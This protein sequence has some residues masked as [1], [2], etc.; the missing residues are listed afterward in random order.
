MERVAL[1][2]HGVKT[3]ATEPPKPPPSY[4]LLASFPRIA[5]NRSQ[6]LW[7]LWR[8]ETYDFPRLS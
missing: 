5:S 1:P 2:L 6:S 7:A 8:K 4:S 3:F